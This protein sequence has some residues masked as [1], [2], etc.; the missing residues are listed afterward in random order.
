[1]KLGEQGVLQESTRN[2]YWWTLRYCRR[3]LQSTL[4]ECPPAS[5]PIHDPPT[6]PLLRNANLPAGPSVEGWRGEVVGQLVQ[7]L[8]PGKQEESTVC[9]NLA[10]LGGECP[11]WL[12]DGQTR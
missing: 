7:G 8:Q 4:S 12:A 9:S 3:A 6:E 1:M 5:V 10:I 11:E 2:G